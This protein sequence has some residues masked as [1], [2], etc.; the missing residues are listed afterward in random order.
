MLWSNFKV[1][2]TQLNNAIH[3]GMDLAYN[4]TRYRLLP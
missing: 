1:L 3:L 2:T 4:G